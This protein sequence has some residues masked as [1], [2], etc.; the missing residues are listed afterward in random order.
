MK[1]TLLVLAAGMGSRYGGLKQVEPVGPSGEMLIDYAVY[2]AI[3]SGFGRVVFVIRHDFEEEFRHRIGGRYAGRIAV[4]YAFQK[5]DDLPAG[6]QVRSERVKPWGTAHAVR[7]ARDVVREPFVMINADDFYGLE[8]FQEL[9]GFLTAPGGASCGPE[10]FAM[11]GYHLR[12]TL[13]SYGSVARGICRVDDAGMLA[14]VTEMTQ[15]VGVPGGAENRENPAAPVRLTGEELVSMNIWGFTPALFA[16]L[17]SRFPTWLAAHG[18]QLKS[19]WYIPQ[20]VNELI[21][22]KRATVRVLTSDSSWFGVT[23]R[24]DRARVTAALNELVQAGIYPA[25]LWP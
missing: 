8:A 25:R 23:Y 11:V 5:A 15:V 10:K 9:A 13:S 22:E 6:F 21:H 12:K 24:E 18:A 1:P 16:Q 4:D 7:A 20:V 14:T 17:E 3:R 19:E 2:D